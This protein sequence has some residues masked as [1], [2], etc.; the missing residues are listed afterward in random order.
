MQCEQSKIKAVLR[1]VGR[2]LGCKI[3]QTWCRVGIWGVA[4]HELSGSAFIMST[5]RANDTIGFEE[6]GIIKMGFLIT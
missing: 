1:G 3:M 2:M 5:L 6:N 4:E